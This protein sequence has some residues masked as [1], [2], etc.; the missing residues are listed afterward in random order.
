[1]KK[2]AL[3]DLVASSFSLSNRETKRKRSLSEERLQTSTQTMN[4]QHLS[5]SQLT[6]SYA[7]CV[8]VLIQVKLVYPSGE[9][10]IKLHSSWGD[11]T[12]NVLLDAVTEH[13]LPL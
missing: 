9:H 11:R 12:S 5:D 10:T 2:S 7:F 8:N 4:P 6:Y 3:V 1:M 13:S